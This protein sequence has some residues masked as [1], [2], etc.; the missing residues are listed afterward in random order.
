MPRGRYFVFVEQLFLPAGVMRIATVEVESVITDC[1]DEV[2]N[3]GDGL[4]D[5]AD[6]GCEQSRDPSEVDP[7]E[8]PACS[9]GQDDDE[10]MLVD[11]PED[12]GC[13][14]AGDQDEADF[15]PPAVGLE[16]RDGVFDGDPW[17]VC[18]ADEESAWIAANSRGNYNPNAICQLLGYERADMWGGTCGTVCGY[19][20]D[21]GREHYDNGGGNADRLGVTVHWHCVRVP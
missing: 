3:D 5:A 19:C 20:N 1:N 14:A 9:N 11:W 4:V 17:R 8:P 7:A 15:R 6:P 2:D 12:P 10:D 21:V 18:R 13:D 16:G